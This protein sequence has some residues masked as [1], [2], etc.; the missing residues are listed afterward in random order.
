MVSAP[1]RTLET[2]AFEIRGGLR[3]MLR[4][5]VPESL[6]EG[7]RG[8]GKTM[9]ICWWMD[10]LAE[11]YPGSRALIARKTQTSLTASAL[12]TLQTKILDVKLGLGVVT[13]FGGSGSKPPAFRYQNGSEIRYCGLDNTE[14]IK[15]SEYD[16]IYINEATELNEDEWQ[17]LKPLLRNFKQPHQR[18]VGDC[19][20]THDK[21]WLLRRCQ[22]GKT[23]L[24]HSALED[25]PAYY[26]ED[27]S[28]TRIGRA[29]ID[30]LDALTGTRY[31]RYRLG[32]WVGVENAIYATFSRGKHLGV[33]RA[34]TVWTDGAIGVDYGDVHPHA[35]VAVSRAST[36]RLWVREAWR[37]RSYDELVANVGRMRA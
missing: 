33:T 2:P 3:A 34:D 35:L 19:N 8:T 20:P 9:G 30:T 6:L 37:G 29:Y 26:D 17:D 18:L 31:Q 22:E 28:L 16:F 4:Q 36:G 12:V 14:K 5:Q 15:S 11:L 32:L 21:H 23:R 27:G 24:Y 10:Y 25:N 7:P 13:P 1:A